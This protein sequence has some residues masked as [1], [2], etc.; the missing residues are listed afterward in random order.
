M[1]S[2]SS[3]NELVN[4]QDFLLLKIERLDSP[5]SLDKLEL[6]TL[7]LCGKKYRHRIR[8]TV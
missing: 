2:Y 5:C 1:K 4:Y 7:K 8:G 6:N 3:S